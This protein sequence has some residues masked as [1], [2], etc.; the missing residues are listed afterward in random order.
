MP[1]VSPVLAG[2]PRQAIGGGQRGD[3]RDGDDDEPMIREFNSQV[4]NRVF[5][6]R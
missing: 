5:S 3:E 4:A 6:N 2:H 1:S